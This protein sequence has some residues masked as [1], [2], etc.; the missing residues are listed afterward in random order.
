MK[1]M[2]TIL[3]TV[4]LMISCLCARPSY[5]GQV[6]DTVVPAIF[7]Y[8]CNNNL[9]YVQNCASHDTV[10]GGPYESHFVHTWFQIINAS[11]QSFDGKLLLCLYGKD[12]NKTQFTNNPSDPQYEYLPG[13]DAS[14]GCVDL[15]KNSG[16]EISAGEA[17]FFYLNPYMNDNV[18]D[19]NPPVYGRIIGEGDGDVYLVFHAGG[20]GN[21][22]DFDGRMRS[23][24][25]IIVDK[26]VIR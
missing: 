23:N 20:E 24:A 13:W 3:L 17:V 25:S 1:R 21:T 10:Y 12:G 16:G 18:D 9:S 8:H 7:A 19:T 22:V 4:G 6:I 26:E 14:E 2:Y 15:V 5:A 11:R